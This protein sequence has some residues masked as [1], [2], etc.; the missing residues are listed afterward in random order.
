MTFNKP[1]QIKEKINL[2]KTIWISDV[3]LGA[4]RAKSE[5]LL[6]FLKHNCSE[7]L[8]IVGDLFDG[9]KLRKKFYWEP[10][11][12]DLI[13]YI[14]NLVRDGVQVIYLTGN[15]DEFLRKYLKKELHFH[16]LIITDRY[17][18]E[19]N[20]DKYLVIHGD[21]YDLVSL[22]YKWAAVFGDK[23]YGIS[24]FVNCIFNSFRQT[25]GLKPWSF[26][27]YIKHKVKQAVNVISK[28]EK[29]L[30]NE[31]RINGYKGVICGHIHTPV[32]KK[33]D[34]FFYYN[35]GDWV[36]SLSALVEDEN[37]N[38]KLVHWKEETKR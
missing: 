31:C 8:F 15:H 35:C 23:L 1:K 37:G 2:Y 14:L 13:M 11:Y 5:S 28:Y 20:N 27:K 10:I 36:E 12:T 22:C 18:Y 38:I 24:I 25:L 6:N 29:L 9:W 21:Q 4:K 19:S 32:I 33:I 30:I 26:S 16:N 17:V 3:H 7:K 34:D